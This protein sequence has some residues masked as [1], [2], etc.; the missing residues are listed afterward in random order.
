MP[1]FDDVDGDGDMDILG[2]QFFC[3]GSFAYY[4]NLSMEQFGVCDSINKYALETYA[5]G[6]FA[7]RSGLYSN[8]AVGTYN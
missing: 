5:W 7:L 3:V 4:K 8:V 6:R 2:Q 1:N